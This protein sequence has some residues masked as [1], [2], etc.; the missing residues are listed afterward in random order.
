[1]IPH[2]REAIQMA[3]RAAERASTPDVKALAA[4]IEAAQAPEITTMTQWLKSWGEDVPPSGGH[5]ATHGGMMSDDDMSLLMGATGP[6]FD[7]MFLEMMTEHHKGAI[8]MARTEQAKGAYAPAKE[9]AG[10]IIAAQQ[11]EID[12]MATLLAKL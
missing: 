10:K 8:E 7:R 12:E 9:L 1:M 11:N 5:G 4:R 2:H 3:E 6:A